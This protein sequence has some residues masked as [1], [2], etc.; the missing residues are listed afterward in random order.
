[1]LLA[2]E[3]KEANGQ[4][5]NLGH[6]HPVSLRE[7]AEQLIALYPGGTYELVPFP[8]ARKVIDIGDY[9]GDFGK[10]RRQLGWTP[11]TP[12]RDGLRHTLEFYERHAAQYWPIAVAA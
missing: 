8:A 6:D 2:A 1:L 12:L 10:I 4:V 5:F 3:S 9:Y 11:R 7:T